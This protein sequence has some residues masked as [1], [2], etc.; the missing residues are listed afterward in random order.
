MALS[1]ESIHQ[2]LNDFFLD[3]FKTAA[4]SAIQF[5]FDRF[6]SVVSDQ[7]FIDANHPEL[8]YLPALAVEKF[9]D[10]VNH[11][12]LDAGDGVNIVLSADSIDTAYFY[13]LL[14]PASPHAP[15]GADEATKEAMAVTFNAIKAQAQK[16]WNSLTLESISGMMLQF[17][18]STATPV[19]WYDAAKTENWTHHSFKISEA[20]APQANGPTLQLWKL[21]LS[22]DF[23]S[24]VIQASQASPVV[25]PP[26]AMLPGGVELRIMPGIAATRAFSALATPLARS[27][28]ALTAATAMP[29]ATRRVNLDA[30]KTVQS[31]GA[32]VEAPPAPRQNY[33][34]HFHALDLS[35]RLRVNQYVQ[36][37]QPTQPVKTNEISIAFDYCLVNIHRPWYMD[38]FVNDRSWCIPG[39]AKGGLTASGTPGNLPMLSIGFVAIRNLAIEANWS[40]EDM[41]NAAV[42][43]D[44]GPF[45][46][47]ADMANNKLSHPG[48]QIVGWMLQTMPALPP[49]GATAPA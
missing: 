45:K 21:K 14:A 22:D 34:R 7:D 10:L 29:L 20:S 2:P 1:L 18:P 49:N 25:S 28:A 16:I 36:A 19:N 9:S 26:P 42:A 41:A 17:K 12:P 48:L 23:L 38:A 39:A 44:F 3:Q 31:I 4:D 33:A 27:A 6:G 11:I 46:V 37:N 30:L 40:A 15:D 47:S 5:R 35:D 8:G 13:R 24:Q 43:T 32:A